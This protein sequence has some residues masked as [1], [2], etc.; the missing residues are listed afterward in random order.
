MFCGKTL[1]KQERTK[2]FFWY[3]GGSALAVLYCFWALNLWNYDFNVP[4]WYRDGDNMLTALFAK[5]LTDG[6]NSN[7][8]LGAPFSALQIDFPVFGDTAI[9]IVEW[10]LMLLTGGNIGYTINGFYILLFPATYCTSFYVLRNLGGERWSSF[11]GSILYTALPYRI[12]RGTAHLALSNFALIPFC[13]YF[14]IE[15]YSGDI[16]RRWE[17]RDV[18]RLGILLVLMALNGI[19]YA[20]FACFFLFLTLILRF[21]RDHKISKLGIFSIATI[22]AS[23][24]ISM[25]PTLYLHTIYGDNPESPAR[26]FIEAEVYGLKI[27]QFFIP[28]Q[29]H[30]ISLLEKFFAQYAN[31]AVPNEGSEYLGIIGAV[32]LLLSLLVILGFQKNDDRLQLLAKLNLGAILLATVGGFG[33]IFAMVISPQIRAYNR[34]SVFVAFFSIAT[35]VILV[36][37]AR[38][39]IKCKNLLSLGIV[40][41]C[42]I[43]L[44]EQTLF[45]KDN[46]MQYAQSYYSDEEF[47]TQ[48]ENYASEGAMIY[49]YPYYKFPENPPINNMGDYALARGYLHSSNL[50]WSYGDYKGRQADLWNRVL[51]EKS[52][53]EQIKIITVVGFEG[54]YIDS[55]A[56]TQEQLDSL[57]NEIEAVIG[58]NDISFI[59]NDGRLIFYGLHQYQEKL[60]SMYPDEELEKM[61]KNYMVTIQY[62]DGFS[63]LE[64]TEQDNWRWCSQTGIIY[65]NNP[66]EE[67]VKFTFDAIVFTGYEEES[68]LQISINNEISDYKISSLGTNVTFECIVQPGKNYIYFTTDAKQVDAPGDPRPLY[69][70]LANAIVRVS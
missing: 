30:G 44:I 66:H 63:G 62:A 9:W 68:N 12:L 22:A 2:E 24:L 49:Q 56:Y 47:V 19:Y 64:G 50:K 26:S 41:V 29:T 31:A 15:I 54:I 53:S 23:I 37:K 43:S 1:W 13:L 45:Q 65:L 11:L 57:L 46:L 7:S 70:R 25:V 5:R 10:L 55:Y 52:I 60:R 28:N 16:K 51:S 14:C 61:K 3:L 17:K 48:I 34:I 21:F 58:K 67:A 20:F 40:I 27:D 33:A 38:Y 32:G 6:F 18:F 39:K 36:D 4:F 35:F 42:V 8:F 59:S 69:F